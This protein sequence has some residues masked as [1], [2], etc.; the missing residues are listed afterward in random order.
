MT[1]L[2][3]KPYGQER[4]DLRRAKDK[5]RQDHIGVRWVNLIR[6]MRSGYF[7]VQEQGIKR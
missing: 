7:Y 4:P 2:R 5:N 6:D 1:K 3:N